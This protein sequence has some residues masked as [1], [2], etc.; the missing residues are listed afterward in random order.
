METTPE[1]ILREGLRCFAER[2]YKGATTRALAEAENV[3]RR[4]ERDKRDASTYGGTK[5]AR[6]L[7]AD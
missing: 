5:L 3:R 2:G 1:R 7:L 6:D 4:A